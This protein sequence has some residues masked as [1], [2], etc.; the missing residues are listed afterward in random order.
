M[1]PTTVAFYTLESP[2]ERRGW[3]QLLRGAR[4]E[5]RRRAARAGTQLLKVTGGDD[6]ISRAPAGQLLPRDGQEHTKSACPD[7]KV[8]HNSPKYV[9]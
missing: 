8:T 3:A 7:R 9:Q 2:T 6:V 5:R 1:N 4:T